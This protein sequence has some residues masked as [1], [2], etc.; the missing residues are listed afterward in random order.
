MSRRELQRKLTHLVL[1]GILA[2][3]LYAGEAARRIL[4]ELLDAELALEP[5]KAYAML[6][7]MAGLLNAVVIRRPLRRD[8]VA[9]MLE[10]L[11]GLP[12]AK[13]FEKTVLQLTEIIEG[14]ERDYERRAGYVGLLY[15]VIGVSASY[16]LFEGF[17]IYGIGGL[18]TTDVFA[19]LVGSRAGR[20]RM[21]FSDGTLEG[22]LAGFAAYLLL[23]LAFEHPARAVA[24]ALASSMAELYGVEDNL[25]I[26]VV[27]S[28]AAWAT[29]SL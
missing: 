7:L 23:L 5:I 29:R 21:P 14:M 8:E 24:I 25:S 28:F 1:L 2:A 22:F 11:E 19:S 9:K 27:A 16:M 20:R 13:R 26:P 6:M 17:A 12:L 18:A 15:G 4:P 3:P 10:R